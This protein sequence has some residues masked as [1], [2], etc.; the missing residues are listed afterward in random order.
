M[1]INQ[2]IA[3]RENQWKRLTALTDKAANL[4]IAGLSSA[5]AEEFFSLYRLASSDLNLVQ[6]RGGSSALLDYLE[7]LVA[8]AY[9]HVAVPPRGRFF[10]TW[11][12]ILRYEFPAAARKQRGAL[13]LSAMIM[14]TGTVA[15]YFITA[16]RPQTA[17]TFVPAQFFRQNPAQRV[18]ERIKR[19]TSA[20]FHYTWE[21][22][23]LFS[24]FLFTHNIEVA[25][26]TF[27]LGASFGIGTLAML[28]FTGAMLGALG[29]RYQA[30]RVGTYFISWVG[31]HGVLELPAI[32][33]AAAAGLIIARAMWT[34]GGRHGG[35]WA[36]VQMQRNEIFYLLI[37][38]A[39]MLVLAGIIEGGFS[40]LTAP[41]I[42]YFVKIFF[43]AVL[44]ASLIAYLFFMPLRKP[45]MHDQSVSGALALETG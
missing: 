10:A 3:R 40:Q 28:F 37:G 26:L 15:G 31:P 13:A 42:P 12:R 34:R 29:Q 35:V 30:D 45:E 19:Q 24:V 1:D 33:V 5:E 9:Q 17:L 32:C 4:T 38:C 16:A 43:A 20:H 21:E 44:F 7:N 39:H 25:V 23:L 22:N 2:F 11:W 41:V 18:A 36:S 6:T 27:A 8:R 14:F